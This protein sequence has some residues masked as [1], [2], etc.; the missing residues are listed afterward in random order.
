MEKLTAKE[1]EI[2]RIFWAHGDLFIQD[3]LR[4]F[5]EPKPH[6]NTVATQVGFLEE[7]G[8]L[9]R[10]KFAN[11]YRYHAAVSEKDFADHT[12]GEMVSQFYGNSYASVVSR[13]VE[14]EKMGLDELKALIEQIENHRK[15]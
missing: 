4:Y 15:P 8:Y 10:E 2:L 6:Y 5:K 13:F 7:K 11:A 1:E 3:L 14:E 12:I 9:V